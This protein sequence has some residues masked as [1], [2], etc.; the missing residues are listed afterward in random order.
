MTIRT[1]SAMAHSVAKLHDA[2]ETERPRLAKLLGPRPEPNRVALQEALDALRLQNEELAVAD[3][4]LR[5]Q[6]DEL[7]RLGIALEA[8]RERY[9][10]LF[11]LAPDAH[12]VTDREGVIQEANETAAT[13]LR[14]D[15]RFLRA[16]P[17]ATFCSPTDGD[18]LHSLLLRCEDGAAAAIG[19]R[20]RPRGGGEVH[21]D[22]R[23]RPT[24]RRTHIIWVFR[25][26]ATDPVPDA[27][28][29]L[30]DRTE[31]LERERRMRIELERSNRAKDRFIAVL[32][33]DLRAPLNAILGWTQL[34][35]REHLD[36]TG[37]QR[38]LAT[39]ERNAQA[40]T[41]LIEELLDVS[42]L[43]A[44]K[45]QLSLG[46]VDFGLLVRRSV[47][48]QLPVA[49][50]RGIT[51]E[52][53]C[54]EGLTVIGDR[55]RLDQVLTNV[56]AN[57]LK[58]TPA[59]GTVRVTAE[60]DG[61]SARLRVVDTGKGI[62]PDLLPI[63]FEMYTQ[64][65]R[66]IAA[67]R[68]LGLGLHIVKQLVELHDGTVAAVSDG[69]GRGTTVTV[70]LPLHADKMPAPSEKLIS[71][72]RSLAR[73]RVLVVDDEYDER[74]L[75]G[76][77]LARAGAEVMCADGLTSAVS[78]FDSWRPDAV[79]SDIAMPEADGCELLAA[80]R[81]KDPRLAAVAVSGFTF[82]G[83]T[84]RA[85]KS[86]FDGHIGKPIDAAELVELVDEAAHMHHR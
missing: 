60:R 86:G 76:A 27:A 50:E 6:L 37:R 40:Q 64:D 1:R 58:Y 28:R 19:L 23:V 82:D 10:D 14:I 17:L 68:G 2:L 69:E 61:A 54:T 8:E 48:S 26:A 24:A 53:S 20:L 36:H 46:L 65:Q 5:E 3:E 70:K 51:L 47:E 13:L 85:L 34:L 41:K 62:A 49:A 74:E 21:V 72:P 83:E 30:R 67:R 66:D 7:T 44:N 32:A 80:L 22:A 52:C 39:I 43:D 79:V 11:A 25:E 16:K 4:E 12:I 57:A 15:R 63:V 73:L 75:I 78:M 29:L 35:Q 81:R 55:S 42:R 18:A 84:S 77:I 45:L 31:V 38:A 9:A 59:E 33:H 56:L 71:P